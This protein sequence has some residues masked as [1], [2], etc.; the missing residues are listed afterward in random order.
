MNKIAK[1]FAFIGVL[2]LTIK[3][4]YEAFKPAWDDFREKFP[5][6]VEEF[7]DEDLDDSGKSHPVEALKDP[8]NAENM[9]KAGEGLDSH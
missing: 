7:I 3:A 9:A 1:I 4:A 2:A 8:L 5:K 6:E